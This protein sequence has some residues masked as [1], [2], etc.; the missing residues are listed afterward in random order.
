MK[1]EF[2]IVLCVVA[3]LALSAC[4]TSGQAGKYRASNVKT[5]T[6]KGGSA[7][8][9]DVLPDLIIS[10]F[11]SIPKNLDK[12]QVR[13]GKLASYDLEII[14]M[15]NNRGGTAGPSELG[16]SRGAGDEQGVI[17][18]IPQLVGGQSYKVVTSVSYDR[19][20][21]NTLTAYADFAF[22]V[23]ESDETNNIKKL[24]ILVSKK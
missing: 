8:A 10:S 15:N 16:I 24:K 6:V 1:K 3:V 13:D 2:W 22:D 21:E 7:P 4:E 20:L 14:V 19:E 9:E 12:N 17:I 5:T 11:K 23:T 18:P